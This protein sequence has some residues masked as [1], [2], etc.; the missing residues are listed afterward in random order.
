MRFSA[1]VMPITGNPMGCATTYAN[2]NCLCLYYKKKMQIKGIDLQ[3]LSA[4]LFK[5][6]AIDSCVSER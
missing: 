1:N 2:G 3:G 5:I 6:F 4:T